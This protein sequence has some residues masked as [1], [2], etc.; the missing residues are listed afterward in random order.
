[1]RPRWHVGYSEYRPRKVFILSVKYDTIMGHVGLVFSEVSAI[2]LVSG[3]L[4]RYIHNRMPP[5][6]L[7]SLILVFPLV[8]PH[9]VMFMGISD[10]KDLRKWSL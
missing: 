7:H 6:V 2:S 4:V 10:Q 8:R 5:L 1:M 3:N 9:K